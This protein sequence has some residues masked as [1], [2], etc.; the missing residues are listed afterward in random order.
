MSFLKSLFGD[1]IENENKTKPFHQNKTREERL[2]WFSRTRP[3][4]KVSPKIIH[5]LVDKFGDNPMFEAFIFASMGLDLVMRYKKL[6][7]QELEDK[8]LICSAVAAILCDGGNESVK[9]ILPLLQNIHNNIQKAEKLYRLALEA[10]ETA[11][12][13]DEDQISAYLGIAIVAGF[14]NKTEF[15]LKSA[16]QGLDRINQLRAR[17]FDIVLKQKRPGMRASL[18]EAE[19]ALK[20]IVGKFS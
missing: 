5:A 7:M 8:Q 14:F 1:K 15:A 12:I 20:S 6:P 11:I 13:L 10:F 9:L 3:W 2:D 16:L 19:S 17:G 4:H 18:Q